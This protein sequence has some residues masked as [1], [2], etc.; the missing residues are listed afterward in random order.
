RR[1]AL[2]TPARPRRDLVGAGI[3]LAAAACFATLGP[4]SEFAHRGG[5][6]SLTLVAW[7]VV[8]GASTVSLVLLTAGLSGRGSGFVSLRSFPARDL[9]W[10]VAAT[11]ANA[12]LN[13]SVF[14]AFQRAGIV[15]TLL[16]F[17]LYP[18][19]VALASVA[20]FGERFDRTRWVAL[21][22]SLAGSVLVVA[23]AGS[24]GT[25]DGLGVALAFVAGIGQTFYV[26]AARH[27]YTGIP[28]AQAVVMTMSGAALIYILLALFF[29]GAATLLEPTRSFGG[30]WPVL[31]AGIIGAAVPTYLYISGVRR[32]GAP[33]AAILATFEPVVGVTLAAVL[34]GERPALTQ[35]LGGLLIIGAGILLQLRPHAETADHEAL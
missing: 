14:I 12:F 31:L 4:L 32:L 35:L 17:Y 1:I 7:R 27:G 19:W 13:L 6:G 8:L 29:T 28:A 30:L 23:G 11:V 5:V 3:V 26:L 22:M 34:L 20:W 21:A 18:A 10:V 24:L 9:R 33:T 16:I 25:L 15:L 2:V